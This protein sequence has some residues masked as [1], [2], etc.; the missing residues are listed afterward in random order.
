MPGDNAT[1]S[2]ICDCL[3]ITIRFTGKK[4]AVHRECDS[5]SPSR[6]DAGEPNW[7]WSLLQFGRSRRDQRFRRRFEPSF[8]KTKPALHELGL[9]PRRFLDL[10]RRLDKSI[11]RFCLSPRTGGTVVVVLNSH[12]PRR[13]I[14]DRGSPHLGTYYGAISTSDSKLYGGSNRRNLGQKSSANRL[15]QS[16]TQTKH[17]TEH[18]A[19]LDLDASGNGWMI[20]A[21]PSNRVQ[22]DL[23]GSIRARCSR[24]EAANPNHL[25]GHPLERMA[26][27]RSQR[28]QGSEV[29]TVVWLERDRSATRD[30][31]AC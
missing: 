16:R 26:W 27:Q 30:C 9:C 6:V 3:R 4:L 15:A 24:C 8:Y 17:E 10:R 11:L 18:P 31:R 13:G 2:P 19:T 5:G 12:R 23:D 25:A 22:P 28:K 21:S 29:F 20:S 14:P 7:T 1:N